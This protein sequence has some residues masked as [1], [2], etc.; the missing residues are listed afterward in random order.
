LLLDEVSCGVGFWLLL[1]RIGFVVGERSLLS[2]A[3]FEELGLV[4]LDVHQPQNQSAT[5]V[6]RS[7]LRK[8]PHP[9]AIQD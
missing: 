2:S 9:A 8:K 4:E 3:W 1:L 7:Q 6:A 5:A